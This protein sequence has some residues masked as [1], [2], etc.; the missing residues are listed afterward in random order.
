MNISSRAP[1]RAERG[2][3]TSGSLDSRAEHLLRDLAPRVL[4]AVIRRFGDF[5][6]AEDAVQEALLAAAMQ[7]PNQGMPESP[8]GWLIHVASRRMTDHVRSE[9][10]RQR[11][12]T[13]AV[14]Q[15]PT[16]TSFSLEDDTAG[17]EMKHQTHS[18][19]VCNANGEQHV[20]WFE[21][22]P[23]ANAWRQTR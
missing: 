13:I 10:A 7:W 17:V 4:G 22:L 12:E 1:E 16:R 18:N 8:L 19:T 11:R 20:S 6:A 5:A 2:D 21:A 15:R 3:G 9:Q 14:S 23:G